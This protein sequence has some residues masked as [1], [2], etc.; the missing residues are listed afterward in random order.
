MQNILK[1]PQVYFR[2]D[3]GGVIGEGHLFRSKA[4]AAKMREVGFDPI[5]ITRPDDNHNPSLFSPYKVLTLTPKINKEVLSYADWLGMPEIEDARECLEMTGIAKGDIWI[6]DHYGIGQKWEKIMME[7]GV[8]LLTIDDLFR[9]HQSH[10]ILDHNLTADEKKYINQYSNTRFLMGPSYA[11]LRDD[12][13]KASPYD[14]HTEKSSYLLFLGSVEKDLFDK[15]LNVIRMFRLEKLQI[16]APP[17]LMS[18]RNNEEIITFCNDLPSLYGKQK[19][20]FGSCG[21]AH[22]ERIA[23]GVPSITC[24]IVDNQSE[25]GKKTNELDLTFHLG[26]LR[27]LSSEE[28]Y[29]KIDGALKSLG[30]LEEKAK[31]GRTLIRLDGRE[32]VV[33]IIQEEFSKWISR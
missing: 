3:R 31:K 27:T 18:P 30:L 21:V 8:F 32:S 14:Y 25:V 28:L 23:L 26:D 29:Q 15:F 10:I 11:L 13:S 1:Y 5:F 16:L 33:K 2:V 6:V 12:I 7:S 4:L 17:S 19:I 20:V 22:L 24:V 9:V